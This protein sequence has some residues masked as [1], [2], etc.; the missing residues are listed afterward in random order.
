MTSDLFQNVV[1]SPINY[2]MTHHIY[3]PTPLLH[4]TASTAVLHFTAFPFCCSEWCFHCFHLSC[5]SNV[6][7]DLV[8]SRSLL[9]ALQEFW[10]CAWPPVLAASIWTF[11]ECVKQAGCYIQPP[12]AYSLLSVNTS[13][14]HSLPGL[15]GTTT[16][17]QKPIKA[18][19]L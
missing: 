1:S 15:A 18:V 19:K 5:W 9:R 17:R 14:T 8:Y 11:T 13:L 10:G 16:V 7:L 6:C 4:Q 2:V 3:V 12:G